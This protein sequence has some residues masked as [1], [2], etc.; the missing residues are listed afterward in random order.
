MNNVGERRSNY[1]VSILGDPMTHTQSIALLS[2]LVPLFV[3]AGASAQIGYGDH[4]DTPRPVRTVPRHDNGQFERAFRAASNLVD[5]AAEVVAHFDSTPAQRALRHA[6]DNLDLA[7]AYSRRGD[8]RA[9]LSAVASAESNA[10]DAIYHAETLIQELEEYRDTAHAAFRRARADI[11]HHS[12]TDRHLHDA[13]DHIEFGESLMRSHEYARAR[14]EFAEAIDELETARD[15][16]LAE[17]QRHHRTH[18]SSHHYTGGRVVSA[19]HHGNRS[20]R[21][22]RSW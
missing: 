2:F 22:S 17:R 3:G 12:R 10:R 20:S 1:P 8:R 14:N 19:S 15:A 16:W 18:D 4:C 7:R 9:A 11:G 13:E 6:S 21:N 5:E